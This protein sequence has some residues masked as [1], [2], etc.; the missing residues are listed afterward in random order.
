MISLSGHVCLN[1]AGREAVAKC[2]GCG[3]LFC[4]ECVT[5]HDDRVLCAGCLRQLTAKAE[6]RRSVWPGL[7]HAAQVVG[8]FLLA[9]FLF[10]AAAQVLLSIPADFH[11]GTIW[12]ESLFEE[13]P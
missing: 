9:W 11:D 13:M 3:H 8:G 1:H 7:L 2:P 12:K 10:H 6:E 5:E 4:R